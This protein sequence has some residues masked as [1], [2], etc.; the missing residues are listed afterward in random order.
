MIKSISSRKEYVPY[1]ALG[2]L[3]LVVVR[4]TLPTL[5]GWVAPSLVIW[6]PVLAWLVASGVGI[7]A[8]AR[9]SCRTEVR[10]PAPA[11]RVIRAAPG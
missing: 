7:A 4:F 2:A 1:V 9:K 10:P 3:V 8:Y 11:K 6:S 5:L